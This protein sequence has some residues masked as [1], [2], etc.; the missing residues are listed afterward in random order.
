M[1]PRRADGKPRRRL[2]MCD[3]VRIGGRGTPDEPAWRESPALAR[4]VTMFAM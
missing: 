2:R 1:R 4:V 3:D